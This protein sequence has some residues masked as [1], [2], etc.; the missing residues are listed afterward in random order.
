MGLSLLD[1]S[2]EGLVELG[3]TQLGLGRI[4]GLQGLL[5]RSTQDRLQCLGVG[6]AVDPCVVPLVGVFDLWRHDVSFLGLLP[7]LWG[8]GWVL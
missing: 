8:V 5:E 2:C 4:A 7:R 1:E 6:S 3:H